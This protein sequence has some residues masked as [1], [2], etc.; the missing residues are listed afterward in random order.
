MQGTSKSI[1]LSNTNWRNRETDSLKLFCDTT[2]ETSSFKSAICSEKSCKSLTTF[3]TEGVVQ[4]FSRFSNALIFLYK[5]A[6]ISAS[7][8]FLLK[9]GFSL[10]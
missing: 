7:L 8:K 6:Y 9:K 10:I 5:N 1:C 3:C 2:E 4:K